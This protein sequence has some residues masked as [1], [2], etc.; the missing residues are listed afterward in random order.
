MPLHDDLPEDEQD[1]MEWWK[2]PDCS[3]CANR[4]KRR[5]CGGCDNGEF[6]EEPDPE[7]LDHLFDRSAW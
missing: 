7:G 1:E 6:F 4:M 2:F 3:G 5:I